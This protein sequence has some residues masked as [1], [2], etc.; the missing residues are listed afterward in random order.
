MTTWPSAWVFGE[1]DPPCIQGQFRW[2]LFPVG[3]DRYN[4]TAQRAMYEKFNDVTRRYPGL[5]SSSIFFEG[6]ANVAS[7]AVLDDSTAVGD[8]QANILA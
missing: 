2:L 1:N 3:L 6:Y 5:N 7:R 4:T 8:Q